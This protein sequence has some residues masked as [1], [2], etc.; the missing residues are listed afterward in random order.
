MVCVDKEPEYP[1][2]PFTI[3][4]SGVAVDQNKVLLVRI[5]YGHRGWMLPGGYAKS[6]ETIGEAIRREMLEETGL[7]VEPLELVSVRSRVRDRRNDIY[8]TFKVKV[9]GGELRPDGKEIAE[10]KYFTVAEMEN[11]E[12]VPKLNLEIAR[13]I[14]DGEKSHF[15]LSGYRPAPDEMYELWL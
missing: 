1:T 12:D 14:F 5:M 3:G 13:H 6:N 8:V 7:I 11:R 2:G 4:V 15:T 9:L 10:A